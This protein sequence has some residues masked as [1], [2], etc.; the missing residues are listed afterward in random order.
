MIRI[1]AGG[2]KSAGWVAEACAEY[3]KRLKKPFDI[4]WEIYDEDKLI[5]KRH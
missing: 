4:K 1:I 3:Q 5:K 2:K